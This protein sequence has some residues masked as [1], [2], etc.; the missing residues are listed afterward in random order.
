MHEARAAL[1]RGLTHLRAGAEAASTLLPML[2]PDAAPL[3]SLADPAAALGTLEAA[4]AAEGRHDEAVVVREL[5]AIA[6]GLDDGAH[7][8]LRSRRHPTD[9][10]APVP[11]VLDPAMMRANVVPEGVPALL[12]DLA[13]AIAGATSKFVRV[14][15]DE[16]GVSPRGPT[17]GPPAARVPAG[18][19]VRRRA[20]GRRRERAGDASAGGAARDAVDVMPEALLAQ[21]EPVQTAALVGP[22]V[23]LALGVPWLEDLRGVQAQAVLCARRAP[24][25][26]RRTPPT[27]ATRRCTSAS[28]T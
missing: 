22:L 28:R 3:L 8:E 14:D 21:P 16:L 6:G 4:F 13:A 27:R 1:A 25:A 26:A 10:A 12:L 5:R 19:D 7:A 9:P 17:D 11:A 15:M 18:E 24:G 23:R 20:A 2:V